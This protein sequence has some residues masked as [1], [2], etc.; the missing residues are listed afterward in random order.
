MV[1]AVV[2]AFVALAAVVTPVNAQA[3]DP[4]VGL[5]QTEPDRKDLISHIEVTTCGAALCGKIL[6]AFNLQGQPVITPNVGRP[7]FWDLV[8]QGGG[9]YAD[10]TV[11]VPFLD[12]TARAR[13]ELKGDTLRV[14]GCKGP[15]CNGQNWIR[16]K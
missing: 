4:A 6:A 2:S 14:T 5:W 9:E 12:V 1:C 7:L 13:A 3:A 15:V 10:G 8:P 11:Y 16:V